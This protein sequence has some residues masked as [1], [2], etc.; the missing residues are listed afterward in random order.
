MR[1][2]LTDALMFCNVFELR[3]PSPQ[4]YIYL[5]KSAW[6]NDRKFHNR[7]FYLFQRFLGLC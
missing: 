1:K 6:L 3:K 7:V 2:G 5:I 4:E